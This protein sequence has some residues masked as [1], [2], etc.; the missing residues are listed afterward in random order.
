[1]EHVFRQQLLR[2]VQLAVCAALGIALALPAPIAHAATVH[3]RTPDLGVGGR[4]AVTIVGQ[5]VDSTS[6][7]PVVGASVQVLGTQLGAV[8]DSAGQYR[9]AGVA[10]GQQTLVAR[11]VG[12]APKRHTVTVGT[13]GELTV[14]FALAAAPT[15]LSEVIVTGTA[16]GQQRRE[17]GNAV[18]EVK[19]PDVLAKSQAPD[20]SSLLN[21]RVAGVSIV[22]STG[23]LGAGPQIEIRGV[24]SL[25]L[26]NAPL[27]YIDGVRV[28]NRTGGGP[29]TFGN[30]GFG[31]QNAGVV[32][33][34]NDINPD[35]IESIQ[36]IK[37]PAAATIYGTEAANGVIQI[38]TKKGT[39]GKPV[40]NFQ[41]QQGGVYFRNPE[42]RIATNFAPD[43]TGAITAFNAIQSQDAKGR[44][45]F[46]TGKTYD[47]NAS[48]AGGFSIGNYFVSSNYQ[49]EHGVEPNNWLTQYSAHANLNLTPDPKYAI[50]T[51][52]NYVQGNY[53]TGAD[54]GL[55]A[56]LGA[57]LGQPNIFA[58]PGADGFYPNVPPNVPQ[59]LFDN[60]DDIHRFTG[61]ATFTHNPISWFNQ[62]LI[63]GLDYTN[64]DGRGLEL[65]APPALAPFT[66]G[67]AAGR[68]G[69]TLTSTTLT[70]ADYNGTA[71]F[72]LTSSI[73]SATSLG[74]QW[75]RTALHESFLGG[76]GF[77]GPGITTVSGTAIA[78]PSTQGDTINTTIG[79]YGQEEIGF[80][81]RLFLTGA[82][83]VDNNSSFGSQFKW[84]TY[85]KVSASWIVSEEPFWKLGFVNSLKLRAAY[86]ESGRAPLAFSAL[87]SYLPVQGPGGTNAFTAGAFGNANL[88]P[89]RGKELEAGFESSLWDRL[90]IDFTYFNKHTTDEIVAQ[91]VAPSLGFTGTQFQ[92]LGQ[93]NNNGIELQATV[94][95]LK[96]P[97]LGWEITGNFATA[98][99]KIISLGGIPSLITT[100]GQANQV[101][102]PIEAYF[103]RKV[104]SATMDPSTGAVSNVLCAGGPGQG[105]VDCSTAP[106]VFIGSSTPTN[107]G[108]VGNTVTLFKKLRLY[109]LVDWKRGFVMANTINQLRC[110][111]LLGVGLCDVNYHP[112]KYSPLYV[113]EA[114]ITGFL[115]QTQ[116][117][118]FQ[119]ASFVKLRE[120][121][122]TYS[123]PDHLLPGID[124]ASFTVAARELKLWTKFQGPDPEVNMFPTG[125]VTGNQGVIPPL[126]RFVATLNLTF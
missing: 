32:G 12:Y 11:R 7:E 15:S 29:T 54:V 95:V 104:V 8:T 63:V 67:N 37:G 90:N 125:L 120:V 50:G 41:I 112:Q 2:R 92:N 76:I 49:D 62:R 84:I 117:Q 20:M 81:D 99:N 86:G 3:H 4:L 72:N 6:K 102:S 123:L 56:M 31:S 122:A 51:S 43:T 80:N 10:R 97:N 17:L 77:P 64:E 42:G 87:R 91:S 82:L 40:F 55:S 58:V 38:I 107:T 59:A 88:K 61:S 110:D 23:R 105:P 100:A 53:H 119:D 106:F 98:H 34:L 30:G 101:G 33:R 70:S 21:S 45:V 73:S 68:I 126:S 9:I 48:V 108:S 13:D 85:P 78:L 75:Y 24:S 25:S 35:E 36:I 113:A 26:D 22:P 79:G 121:S 47:Y 93:V 115:S 83:R 39:S 27:I 1:M 57:Q 52:L 14:D 114:G 44:P 124:H 66:L 94:Q 89:E 116:D 109:A 19:A 65:F 71:K 60:S 103:S 18:G 118:F 96:M 16:G 46:T 28:S 74:G 69:Q 111:G 5:V